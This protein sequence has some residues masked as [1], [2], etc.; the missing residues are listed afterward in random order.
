[1]NGCSI[2]DE[3]VRVLGFDWLML[4]L[5]G[6]LHSSTVTLAFKL[7]VYMLSYPP[8]LARF[9]EGTGGAWLK[10]ELRVNQTLGKSA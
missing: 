4:F 8:L 5:Q 2:P 3:V 10:D 7:L 6:H 1:M 9:R